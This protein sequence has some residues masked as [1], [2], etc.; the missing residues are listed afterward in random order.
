MHG[1]RV[2]GC[3]YL[4]IY[5]GAFNL[6]KWLLGEIFGKAGKRGEPALLGVG[7]AGFLRAFASSASDDDPLESYMCVLYVLY[8]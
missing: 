5:L 1:R 2:C 7:L 4:M 8:V 6:A 3:V